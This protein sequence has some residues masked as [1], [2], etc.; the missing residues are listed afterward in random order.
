MKKIKLL[1]FLVVVS[2]LLMGQEGCQSGGNGGGE[3][4]NKIDPYIGGT[5]GLSI[6]YAEGAPPSEVFDNKQW[7]FDVEVKLNNVGEADVDKDDVLVKLSGL[8]PADFGK[9]ESS[10]IKR[11]INEDIYSTR[12]DFEGNVIEAP[13]VYVTFT[14]LTF[15]DELSGNQEFPVRADVCYT[16]ETEA[17]ADGCIREDVLSVDAD[18][19]C[20]VNEE[21]TVYNSGAP[22]QVTAFQEQS[23]GSDKVRYLFTIEHQGTGRV[24]LPRSE[25]PS[26]RSSENKIHFKIESNVA[27][28]NCNGL[29]DGS[30]KEGNILLNNG[31]RV[32]QCVQ[33][34]K[35]NLDYIDKVQITLSYDYKEFFEQP[36]LIKKSS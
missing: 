34:T 21:K 33:Q 2:F 7:T 23:S 16:Y 26:G 20:Q 25:C 22:I 12:K 15:Q 1:L 36:L 28:L 3:S 27:D 14:G 17:Q 10:F 31:Q 32:L 6:Q 4:K 18:A 8:N 24:F 35:S 29:I 9:T 11:G 19:V 30:G 13:E 5:R